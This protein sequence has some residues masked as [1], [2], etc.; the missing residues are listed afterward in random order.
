[1]DTIGHL[2]KVWIG[3]ATLLHSL[4]I[5]VI[6]TI[7]LVFVSYILTDVVDIAI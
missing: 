4:V 2:V 6:S 5:F 3:T 7:L 1:M